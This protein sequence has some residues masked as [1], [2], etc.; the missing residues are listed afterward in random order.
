MSSPMFDL[1]GHCPI[2]VNEN[3]EG[4]VS[5]HDR[6][7]DHWSCWCSDGDDCELVEPR[8]VTSFSRKLVRVITQSITDLESAHR[9]Q[10]YS[11]E[12]QA[13]GKKPIGCM[14]C[15]PAEGS[16]PCEAAMVAED[17]KEVIK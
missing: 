16:W 12:A 13:Q 7:F 10:W 5:Y 11:Y 14:T 17:L 2:G 6:D 15:Y 4:P 8:F 9:P 3:G 1:P